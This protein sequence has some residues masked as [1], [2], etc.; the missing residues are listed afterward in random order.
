MKKQKTRKGE[1]ETSMN[2]FDLGLTPLETLF[3][4]LGNLHST[5][6]RTVS[7]AE[8]GRGGMVNLSALAERPIKSAI[9]DTKGDGLYSIFLT[10]TVMPDHGPITLTL[11]ECFT[12]EEIT[13]LLGDGPAKFI[14][15]K[16]TQ[17][18]DGGF[19]GSFKYGDAFNFI[20]GIALA[21]YSYELKNSA[22]SHFRL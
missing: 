5:I 12:I 4:Q 6:A 11:E 8:P 13:E 18:A 1:G 16:S 14:A 19:I 20:E 3:N 15:K 7:G 2:G 22:A 9:I 10:K 21:D 17:P